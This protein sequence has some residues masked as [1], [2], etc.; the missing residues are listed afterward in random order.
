MIVGAHAVAAHGQPRATGD[1]DIWVR[2]TSDNAERV[3]SALKN[4]GAPLSNLSTEDLSHSGTV[5]Q[6]GVAPS[7]IDVLTSI[8][9]VAFDEAWKSKIQITIENLTIFCI[10]KN[11]LLVNKKAT[12]RPKDLADVD[13]LENS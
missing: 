12:G 7:R 11:E 3:F 2:A 10:G 9:G 8:T 6:I 13:L 4:F 1:L 5:F